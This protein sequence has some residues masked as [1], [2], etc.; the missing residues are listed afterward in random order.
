[1]LFRLI[2][3]ASD[4]YL[5]VALTRLSE[6]FKFSEALTGVTLIALANGSPDV[7]SSMVAGGDE[8]GALI[9]IG[10]LYGASLFVCN[11]VFSSVVNSTP[12]QTLRI[13]KKIFVRDV[14]TF[15]FVTTLLIVLGFLKL[16]LYYISGIFFSIYFIYV[17]IV[18]IMEC[19]ENKE[20]K[21]EKSS[22]IAGSLNLD[23][24]QKNK[25]DDHQ[26]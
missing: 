17:V 3:E 20:K 13:P 12:K 9:S 25:T 8:G 14:A 16:K 22:S 19:Q 5:S 6:R 26:K 11:L 15:F 7:I 24:T 10:A 2:G 21:L 23:K 1:L 18:L 4:E